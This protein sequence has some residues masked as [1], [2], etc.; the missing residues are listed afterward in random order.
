M[1]RNLLLLFLNHHRNLAFHSTTSLDEWQTRVMFCGNASTKRNVRSVPLRS[2]HV[3]RHRKHQ[4]TTPQLV[5][6]KNSRKNHLPLLL[7][8]LPRRW[9]HPARQVVPPRTR[10]REH[11]PENKKVANITTSGISCMTFAWSVFSVGAFFK[12]KTAPSLG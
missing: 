3:L 12:I 5:Y 2:A 9:P 4:A 10:V 6:T 11:S 7:S 8:R 1:A